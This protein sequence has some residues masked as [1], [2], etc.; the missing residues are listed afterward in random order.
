MPAAKKPPF[1]TLALWLHENP[2]VHQR[3]PYLRFQQIPPHIKE[4]IQKSTVVKGSEAQT[5]WQTITRHLKNSDDPQ[6]MQY[7][8]R[9]GIFASI[10][11]LCEDRLN[12]LFFHRSQ[13][14][15]GHF[16]KEHHSD[17]TRKANVLYEADDVDAETYAALYCFPEY[18]NPATHQAHYHAMLMCEEVMIA[19]RE[20]Q[21]VLTRLRN[22]QKTVLNKEMK[23][24]PADNQ[25]GMVDFWNGLQ[26]GAWYERTT[27]HAYV[28]GGMRDVMP[29]R[30]GVPLYVAVPT[31]NTMRV[32]KSLKQISNEKT[33][34]QIAQAH[35]AQQQWYIP[36]FWQQ[37][38]SMQL[39]RWCTPT[40][41][42]EGRQT[43]TITLH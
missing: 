28:G 14:M 3:N 16:F 2:D 17:V 27:I 32:T 36:V 39:I 40:I 7:F 13:Q 15:F 33:W 23:L 24:F 35:H 19:Y 12:S 21:E 37:S 20:L 34:Q 26:L 30:H 25:Q 29:F 41:A 38:E 5:T 31:P 42:L 4:N 18:R 8:A 9:H 10:V 1:S 43:I 11:S 22:R 6:S